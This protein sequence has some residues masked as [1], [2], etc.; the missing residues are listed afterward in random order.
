MKWLECHPPKINRVRQVSNVSEILELCCRMSSTIRIFSFG[1]G[2]S[3]SRSLIKGLARTT[4]DRFVF[5]P[6]NTN[7]YIY[8]K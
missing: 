4:N 2:I 6:L 1:L 3:P 7:I 8:I 5:I